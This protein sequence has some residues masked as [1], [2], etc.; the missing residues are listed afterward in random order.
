[1]P[2]KLIKYAFL[3]ALGEGVYISLIAL[4][5]SNL[6]RIMGD[7][8]DNKI[9]APITFLLLFVLSTAVSGALVLGK[10]AL[11]YL[12]GRKKEAI[13]LFGFTIFWLFIFFVLMLISLVTFR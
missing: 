3:S 6:G 1:M 5:M 11:M 4:L 2:K 12:D 8:P 10:P 13:Q 9:L 7:T